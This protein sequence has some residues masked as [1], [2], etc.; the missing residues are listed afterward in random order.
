MLRDVDYSQIELRLMADEVSYRDFL[1]KVLKDEQRELCDKC[2]ARRKVVNFTF[3]YGNNFN[4]LRPPGNP[5]L[6]GRIVLPPDV[7]PPS[8]HPPR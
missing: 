2:R 6:T 7:S 1:L 8:K 3:L 5:T 4:M